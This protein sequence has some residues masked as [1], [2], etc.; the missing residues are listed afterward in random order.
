[1]ADRRF[2]GWIQLA[3]RSKSAMAEQK[4]TTPQTLMISCCVFSV[5][6]SVYT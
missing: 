2:E 3:N 6:W 4:V 5:R 1:M